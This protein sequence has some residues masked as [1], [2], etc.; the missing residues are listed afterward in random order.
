MEQNCLGGGLFFPYQ[1]YFDYILTALPRTRFCHEAKL[2]GSNF[3]PPQRLLRHSSPRLSPDPSGHN[4][5]RAADWPQSAHF[6]LLSIS[7][8]SFV[9]HS[10]ALI[11]SPR[12]LMGWKEGERRRPRNSSS[13]RSLSAETFLSRIK[14]GKKRGQ[15]RKIMQSQRREAQKR[16]QQQRSPFWPQSLLQANKA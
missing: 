14:R 4:I 2:K 5:G 13:E 11:N 10:A 15:Q 8:L 3:F 16:E 6:S 9:L 12:Q 1:L 7:Q